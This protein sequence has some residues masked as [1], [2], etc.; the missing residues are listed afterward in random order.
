MA[1]NTN[2]ES[3]PS[4]SILTVPT[5]G[6]EG[7]YVYE[8][9]A[10]E[11]FITRKSYDTVYQD[12]ATIEG[13]V[14]QK[15]TLK[16]EVNGKVEATEILN[17]NENF[18][19]VATLVEGRNDVNLLFTDEVGKVTRQTFNFVYLTNYDL[20]V[21][22]SYTGVAGAMAEDGTGAKVYATVQ[23][24]VDSV[25]SSNTERVVI[26]IKE[27][28]YREHLVITSP[29]IT[30]IGED[31]EK[32]NINFFDSVESP[33]GGSTDKRCAVYVKSSATGFA[34]ENLTIENMSHLYENC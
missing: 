8:D 9:E 21:D 11:I 17:K 14:D 28:S 25:S 6:R 4:N 23:E 2:N 33:V 10:T 7:Q 12:Q 20:V 34:A 5:A 29:Y 13:R 32:V 30:L 1:K 31:R 24:A 15:G 16:L 3:N 22:A 26:L 18:A 19:F 27:G